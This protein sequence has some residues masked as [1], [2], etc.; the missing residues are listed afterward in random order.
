MKYSLPCLVVFSDTKLVDVVCLRVCAGI[1]LGIEWNQRTECSVQTKPACYL[2]VRGNLWSELP[3][4]TCWLQWTHTL[5]CRWSLWGVYSRAELLGS[6]DVLPDVDSQ[7]QNGVIAFLTSLAHWGNRH[8]RDCEMWRYG[9]M[10]CFVVWWGWKWQTPVWEDGWVPFSKALICAVS[11][12]MWAGCHRLCSCSWGF[13]Y[14]DGTFWLSHFKTQAHMKGNS[15]M[16][17]GNLTE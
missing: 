7:E 9:K 8:I 13:C 15:E 14:A 6:A 17:R 2:G 5:Q 11:S 3:F 10:W 4:L 12:E 16:E 1:S